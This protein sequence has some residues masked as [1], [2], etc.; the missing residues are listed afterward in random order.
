VTPGEEEREQD[1]DHDDNDDGDD[2]DDDGTPQYRWSV[3]PHAT[4]SQ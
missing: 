3:R 4:L 2:D 1:E